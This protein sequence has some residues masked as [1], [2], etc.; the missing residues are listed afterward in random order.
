MEC[1]DNCG[2]A[3]SWNA[4]FVGP[5]NSIMN[6][7]GVEAGAMCTDSKRAKIIGLLSATMLAFLNNLDLT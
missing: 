5:A 3:S 2:R 4:K 7:S 1:N 6:F